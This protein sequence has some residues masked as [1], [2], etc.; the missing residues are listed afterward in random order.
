MDSKVG[1]Y[2]PTL[3]SRV[4]CLGGALIV[5]G[6]V[7]VSVEVMLIQVPVCLTSTRERNRD[8]QERQTKEIKQKGETREGNG[9]RVVQELKDRH[10]QRYKCV[11]KEVV[12]RIF[13]QQD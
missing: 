2:H 10:R 1:W 9:T 7:V 11:A 3:L 4:P 12:L 8:Q 5:E 13:H 6:V